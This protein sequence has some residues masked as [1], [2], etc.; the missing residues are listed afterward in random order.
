M[1]A[2]HTEEFPMSAPT[3]EKTSE[4]DDLAA[5]LDTFLAERSRLIGL[6]G[7]VTGAL[8]A[9]DVVQEAWLRWQRVDRR[10]IN[11]AAAFLTT[12]TTNLAIN[13]IQSAQHRREVPT[14]ARMADLFDP[15][16]DPTEQAEQTA[17]VGELL[18][19]LT[20]R[21][22]RAE[23]AAYLLRK[24]FDYP[25]ADIARLLRT[26]PANARQLVSRAQNRLA[27]DRGGVVT[28][29]HHR[30]LTAAFLTAARTGDVRGLERLLSTGLRSSQ[31]WSERLEPGPACSAA[32]GNVRSSTT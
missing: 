21:L 30:S 4:P 2:F 23:L 8:G 11:N 1:G 10:K 15:S 5:A 22:P 32:T 14:E 28:D 6:A 19:L 7:R 26:S 18:E 16:A 25:Y 12:T 17:A 29:D 9:E 24:G 27:A 20:A 31:T 13:V 3:L